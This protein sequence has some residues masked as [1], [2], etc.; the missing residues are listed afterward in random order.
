MKKTQKKSSASKKERGILAVKTLVL[1]VLILIMTACTAAKEKPSVVQP[2]TQPLAYQ[3]PPPNYS[4]PGSIYSTSTYRS[5]Y[6][7]GRARRVGDIVVINVIESSTASQSANTETNRE[8]TLDAGVSALFGVTSLFNVPIGAN[9]PSLGISS[10]NDFEGDG[11]TNRNSNI[12]ATLAARVINVLGNGL[13]E[14]EAVREIKVNNETQFMVVTGLVRTRD[15][16]PDNTIASTQI[17]NAKI[18]YYGE[19]VISAKQKPGW[20]IRFLDAISP[21]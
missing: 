2:I 16:S 3:Q 15:I 14:I 13:M 9:Q 7:D 19:G 18:E 11:S 6:E 12:S 4:N 20:L 21:F 17:A 10:T 1:L 8:S 5:L